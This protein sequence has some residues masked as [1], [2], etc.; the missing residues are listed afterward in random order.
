ME[1]IDIENAR[2][3]TNAANQRGVMIRRLSNIILTSAMEGQYRCLVPRTG[4]N[5]IDEQMK[6]IL[7][8]EGYQARFAQDNI[9]IVV[10]WT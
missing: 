5:E 7:I 8:E 4:R 6:A 9:H 10:S 1:L 3:F 2:G